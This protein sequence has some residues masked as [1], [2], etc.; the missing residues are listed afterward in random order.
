MPHVIY[1]LADNRYPRVHMDLQYKVGATLRRAR[2][3]AGIQQQDLAEALGI[4]VWTLNRLEHGCRS[5]DPE[6]L[7]L[8]PPLIARPVVGLLS[9]HA[10]QQYLNVRGMEMALGRL[11]ELA[12]P[13]Q[14]GSW[15]GHE[16]PAPASPLW[17][18]KDWTLRRVEPAI[19]FH[20]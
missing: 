17:E 10:R 2:I 9:A 12:A 18:S 16:N 19:Y 1:V 20:S 5:F 3:D 8:L 11:T 14:S 13:A 7:E 4:S 15:V 6:W